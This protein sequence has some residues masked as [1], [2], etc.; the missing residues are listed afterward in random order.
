AEEVTGAQESDRDVVAARFLDDHLGPAR[1]D[2]EHGVAG[3][4]L[5]DHL[6]TLLDGDRPHLA[7]QRAQDVVGQREEDRYPLESGEPRP[8]FVG[9]GP[10]GLNVAHAVRIIG[11]PL[12]RSRS[13]QGLLTGAGVGVERGV[14]KIV[15]TAVG[16]GVTGGRLGPVEGVAEGE[17]EDGA[18][19]ACFSV[20]ARKISWVS[21][22]PGQ[23]LPSTMPVGR[24]GIP[25]KSCGSPLMKPASTVCPTSVPKVLMVLPPPPLWVLPPHAPTTILEL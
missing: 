13:G 16:I 11:T 5:A 23:P 22:W 15:G 7:R 14:G 10:L 18:Q 17:G 12:R 2:D 1:G 19:P 21:S 20:P 4:A 9:S 25:L 8:E 24:G 6:D 3:L